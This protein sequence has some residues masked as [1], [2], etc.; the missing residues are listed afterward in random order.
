MPIT[1]NKTVNISISLP[2]SL[3]TA[4]S[5]YA[6]KQSWHLSQLV[7]QALKSYMFLEEWAELRKAFRP[8]SRRLKISSDEQVEKLFK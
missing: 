8:M 4:A 6:Q 7:A 5:R 2:K 3:Q 1:R